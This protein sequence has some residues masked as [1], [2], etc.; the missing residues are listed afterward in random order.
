MVSMKRE[1]DPGRRRIPEMKT[2][3]RRNDLIELVLNA[4]VMLVMVFAFTI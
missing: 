4:G 1:T 2:I 3:A